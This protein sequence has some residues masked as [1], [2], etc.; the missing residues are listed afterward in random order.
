MRVNMH[1]DMVVH[2]CCLPPVDLLAN[3]TAPKPLADSAETLATSL[4][5]LETLM[6]KALQYVNDVVVSKKKCCM[7]ACIFHVLHLSR[8]RMMH[9]A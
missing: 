1:A 4:K 3:G 9:A 8:C 2:T 7:W 5:R 6:D